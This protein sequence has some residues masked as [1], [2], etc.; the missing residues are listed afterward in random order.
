MYLFFFNLTVQYLCISCS[1]Q[2]WPLAQSNLQL[3][4][5]LL[6]HG[7]YGAA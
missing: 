6:W 2:S 1:V 7:F 3:V 5:E 4:M